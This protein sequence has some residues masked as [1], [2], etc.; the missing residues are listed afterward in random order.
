MRFASWDTVV[1]FSTDKV[2]NRMGSGGA[3]PRGKPDWGEVQAI[4]F[5]LQAA[6]KDPTRW[7]FAPWCDFRTYMDTALTRALSEIRA[8]AKATDPN[9]KVGIE[10]TQMP[11]AFGG[12]DLARLATALDWVEPYDIGSAREIFGSFMPV[13]PMLTISARALFEKLENKN[14]A[15]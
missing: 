7:N 5:D 8:A 12:Y 15:K 9:A 11:S 6:R 2:K 3:E 1:P 13:K 10:G 4:K 14:Q